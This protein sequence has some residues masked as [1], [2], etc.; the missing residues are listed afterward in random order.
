MKAN[1]QLKSIFSKFDLGTKIIILGMSRCGKS[2][3]GRLCAEN[4]PRKLIIDVM[5]EYHDLPTVYTIP[6]LIRALKFYK[7][8]KS[9]SLVF[10]LNVG[11]KKQMM[12]YFDDI[13]KL[14]WFFKNICLVVEECDTFCTPQ[15]MPEWWTH[16]LRRG[17]HH[18]I[19]LIQSTQTPCDLNKMVIKQS[20]HKFFGMFSERNDLD[21][22]AKVGLWTYQDLLQLK[23]YHFIHDNDRN[24]QFISTNAD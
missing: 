8:K 24:F 3:L 14:V 12:Q 1:Q 22:C 16:L 4:Y 9:F 18:N 17:R 23:K 21:Y 20:D 5:D 15:L 10:K 11:N 7:D 13:C 6:E 2:Y 19:S